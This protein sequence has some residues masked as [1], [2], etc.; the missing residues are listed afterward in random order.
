MEM[1]NEG[2]ELRGQLSPEGTQAAG[3]AGTVQVRNSE[4][5]PV[6]WGSWWLIHR[7]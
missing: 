6:A 3:A 4:P 2:A 1:Q 7:Q 5:G